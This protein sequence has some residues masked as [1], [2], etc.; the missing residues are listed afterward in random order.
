[1]TEVSAAARPRA[2][3]PGEPAALTGVVVTGAARG[4]G[5]AVAEG[6]AREGASVVGIDI[7][8]SVRATVG[9]LGVGH[10][11]V[12]G[13]VGDPEVLEQACRAAAETGGGLATLVLNAGVTAPGE[14]AQFPVE[15]W[16][17]LLA[18]NLR[19]AFI[20]AKAAHPYLHP[21]SSIVMVSSICASL[22]F[23][24]RAA[25]CASKSGVDGLVRA[26]AVEWA[27]AGVRVNAVAPGT[28]ETEMQA[29]M[30]ASGR[31]STEGYLARIPMG[32]VGK[33]SEIADAIIYLASAKA[34]YVTGVVLPVDGGWANA[35]LP[36][37]A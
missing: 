6:F 18:V 17:R 12:V 19:A 14:T 26:L 2:S 9:A 36:A 15:Q 35:G 4:L 32:R 16:D 11:A 37:H 25:Y 31:V 5:R 10:R 1:M 34:S 33:P 28:I 23:G 20:G 13:D 24:A 27:P 30:V 3:A 29:A 22:G 8:D 7:D 21:G